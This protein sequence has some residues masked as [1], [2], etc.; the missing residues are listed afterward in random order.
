[1]M[2]FSDRVMKQRLS[3]DIY[4]ALQNTIRDGSRLD[5]KVAAAVASAMM[6]S[7][8]VRCPTGT[9]SRT[10]A[11]SAGP[12]FVKYQIAFW[13]IWYASLSERLAPHTKLNCSSDRAGNVLL[14]MNRTCGQT[15]SSVTR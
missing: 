14:I 7:Y 2:V 6:L 10:L 4:I 12:G 1:M 15:A 13:A 9:R 3:P 5:A 8:R 11:L